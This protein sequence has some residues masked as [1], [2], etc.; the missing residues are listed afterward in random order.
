[1]MATSAPS[2][3][4]VPASTALLR[5]C[6]SGVMRH[7]ESGELP[8]YTWTLGLAQED[9]CQLLAYCFPE[10]DALERL[11]EAQYETILRT[12]APQLHQL[13]QLLLSL[14]SPDADASATYW[15]AHVVS[16][17]ASG[18]RHL[19][20]DLGL[21]A[22]DD[23]TA[24]LQHFFAPFCARNTAQLKWK[25]FMFQQL[26]LEQPSAAPHKPDCTQCEQ[27]AVCFP[28]AL[29]LAP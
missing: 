12:A 1:M 4:A 17:A 18:S 23:V 26:A 22:R 8:L 10:L 20:Q 28:P 14:R 5:R 11:P 15:A 16:A 29:T 19:W 2:P 7:A 24:L 13:V 27:H 9:L 6:V 25:R 21:G 3:A